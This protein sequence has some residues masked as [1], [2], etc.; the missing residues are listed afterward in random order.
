MDWWIGRE[1]EQIDE[2]NTNVKAHPAELSSHV[3]RVSACSTLARVHRFP[4]KG[5][6]PHLLSSLPTIP[7]SHK[8]SQSTPL[9]AY[10]RKPC[11]FQDL[12]FFVIARALVEWERL[13][14]PAI[15]PARHRSTVTL[16][17]QDLTY[18]FS[19]SMAFLDDTR[20][21]LEC[22]LKL[23]GTKSWADE[24]DETPGEDEGTKRLH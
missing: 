1:Q 12:A 4:A 5:R 17:S 10:Q 21:N 9:P 8:V 3:G 16:K 23:L 7:S 22:V 19:L 13:N 15:R 11:V 18:A 2:D 20:R 24:D 14:L 6:C